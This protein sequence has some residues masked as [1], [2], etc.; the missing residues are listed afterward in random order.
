MPT[1]KVLIVEDEMIIAD[2]IATAVEQDGYEPLEPA[3]TYSE[4]IER[5]QEH[6]PDIGIFD[7]QLSGKKS[8]IDLAKEVQANYD[9]PFIFLTSNT[10]KKTLNELKKTSPYAFLTKP[11]NQDELYA[12]IEL[13]LY[14]YQ[15][16]ENQEKTANHLK[17]NAIFIKT[18]TGLEKVNFN[19]ILYV[20][21]DNVYV[22]I[23][24]KNG[25]V[26]TTRATIN[27]FQYKLSS[28]FLRIHRSYIINVDYLR[29]INHSSVI[30]EDEEIPLGNKYK[31][32]LMSIIT[33]S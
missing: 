25:K 17:D 15:K 33:V 14:N 18:K 13:S 23:S 27:D 28:C 4:A 21:S 22:D 5:I 6:K 29:S 26:Y 9:F 32:N 19:E 2:S 1:K 8:G 7:I 24:L 11:F 20:K 31:E 3:V 10:D 16:K 12:A 30:I